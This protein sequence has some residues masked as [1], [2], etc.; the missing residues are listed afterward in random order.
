MQD[1]LGYALVAIVN[2]SVDFVFVL[3]LNPKKAA[4][5]VKSAILDDKVF[6]AEMVKEIVSVNPEIFE[7]LMEKFRQK[8]LGTINSLENNILPPSEVKAITKDLSMDVLNQ[9]PEIMALL[10]MF[11]NVKRRVLANPALI[12]TVLELMQRLGP[13]VQEYLR[14]HG[15]I[16]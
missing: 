9:N 2:L 11:P 13:D 12:N 5:K 16:S 6:V 4:S 8:M 10:D 14:K 15:I 1:I 3:L 7:P